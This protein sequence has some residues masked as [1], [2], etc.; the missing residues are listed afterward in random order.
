MGRCPSLKRTVEG[1]DFSGRCPSLKR[2][3]ESMDLWAVALPRQG[4]RRPDARREKEGR[5]NANA[6]Y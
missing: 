5:R 3:V 1:M 4:L 2:T 6:C